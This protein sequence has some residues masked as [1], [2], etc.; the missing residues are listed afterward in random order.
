MDDELRYVSDDL[1]KYENLKFEHYPSKFRNLAESTTT[2]TSRDK[3]L[4]ENS[5]H[6][7]FGEKST[8]IEQ[9]K[10]KNMPKINI[11]EKVKSRYGKSTK[12]V[13]FKFPALKKA[14]NFRTLNKPMALKSHT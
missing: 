9:D 7:N 6:T 14:G 4:V 3:I 5:Q 10:P 11:F 8:F 1:Q 12:N 2:A 13:M